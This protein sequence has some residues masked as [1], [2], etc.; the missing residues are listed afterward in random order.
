MASGVQQP[1]SNAPVNSNTQGSPIPQQ[2]LGTTSGFRQLPTESVDRS[3]KGVSITSGQDYT[4][5]VPKDTP[6]VAQDT[7]SSAV[8]AGDSETPNPFIDYKPGVYSGNYQGFNAPIAA[9]MMGQAGEA[10]SNYQLNVQ[11]DA[12]KNKDGISFSNPSGGPVTVH[13]GL[14]G[15][16]VVTG[17]TMGVPQSAYIDAYNKA[18]AVNKAASTVESVTTPTYVQEAYTQ[19]QEDRE[20]EQRQ[21]EVAQRAL[22]TKSI[23]PSTSSAYANYGSNTG[24]SS[25]SSSGGGGNWTNEGGGRFYAEGGKVSS[26]GK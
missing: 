2:A 5:N 6:S 17:N 9:G 23:V 7:S 10:I 12:L 15:G 13:K 24:S 16:L 1:L 25:S 4:T 19:V 20:E 14:F 18:N 22:A 26:G 3:Y 11:Q 21:E 8:L